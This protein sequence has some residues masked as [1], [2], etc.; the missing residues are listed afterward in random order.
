MT[1]LRS[2]SNLTAAR[3]S[4]GDRHLRNTI[5]AAS[6]GRARVIAAPAVGSF[7]HLAPPAL[8]A[9]HRTRAKPTPSVRQVPRMLAVS[10]PYPQVG[11]AKEGKK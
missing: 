6:G 2:A 8:A 11:A 4:H 5:P 7:R 1:L 3:C 10:R 9:R